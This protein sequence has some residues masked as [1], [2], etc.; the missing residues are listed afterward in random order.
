M[1]TKLLFVIASLAL[2]GGCTKEYNDDRGR[3]DAPIGEIHEDERDVYVFPDQYANVAVACDGTSRMYMTTRKGDVAAT[4][5][6]VPDS[7]ECGAGE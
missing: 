3:G 7:P 1:K 6:V 4:L 2:L 5:V